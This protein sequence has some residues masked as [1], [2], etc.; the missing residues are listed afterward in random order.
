MRFWNNTTKFFSENLLAIEMTKTKIFMDKLVY[1]GVSVLEI[2]KMVMYEFSYD[3]IKSKYGEKAKLCHVD[4]DTFNFYMKKR[5]LLRHCKSFWNKIWY[6][7][8]SIK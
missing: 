6:F 7:K 8:S 2:S 5:H 1:F 3:Y 4:T